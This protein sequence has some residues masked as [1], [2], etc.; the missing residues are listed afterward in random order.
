MCRHLDHRLRH[1]VYSKNIFFAF[2]SVEMMDSA[3]FISFCNTFAAACWLG[4]VIIP[5]G[6]LRF[7]KNRGLDWYFD[8]I[9]WGHSQ[10]YSF[11]VNYFLFWWVWFCLDQTI[12]FC[13]WLL[14]V[15]LHFLIVHINIICSC[16]LYLFNAIF[17]NTLGNLK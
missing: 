6:N 14:Y 2:A 7:G 16:V 4:K 11:W 10:G 12:Y 15:V 8:N 3:V 9:W 13:V 5:S 17:C 1:I